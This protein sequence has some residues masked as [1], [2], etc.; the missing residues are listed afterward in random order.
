MSY[1]EEMLKK[2]ERLMPHAA[3]LI[4]TM[5]IVFFLIDRVNPAMNFIDNRLTKGLLLVMCAAALVNAC[6]MLA[7]VLRQRRIE[8]ARRNASAVLPAHYRDHGEGAY[9]RPASRRVAGRTGD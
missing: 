1:K 6:V 7:P 8:A 5:Y 4:C 2:I 3:I 9:D